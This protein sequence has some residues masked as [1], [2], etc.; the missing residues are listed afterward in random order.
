MIGGAFKAR[1][2]L[3][4]SLVV[5]FAGGLW[6]LYWYPMRA[7]QAV[8]VSQPWVIVL[9]GGVATQWGPLVGAGIM[10]LLAEWIR[11]IKGLGA[12]HQ[13]FFGVLLI[14]IIIFLPNGIVGDFGKITRLFRRAKA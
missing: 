13:A 4:A 7:I 11:S 14:V 2:D 5:F 12:S 10:V 1:P 6:G 9:V 8:G 3:L